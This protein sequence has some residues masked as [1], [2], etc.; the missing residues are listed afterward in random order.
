MRGRWRANATPTAPR[1]TCCRRPDSLFEFYIVGLL[2]EVAHPG[3]RLGRNRRAVLV[4]LLGFGVRHLLV[5]A[6]HLVAFGE[7]VRILQEIAHRRTIGLDD[8][9]SGPLGQ[10]EKLLRREA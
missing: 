10:Y 3:A 9:V 7:I 6:D 4:K 8:I 1:P 2:Q 5:F